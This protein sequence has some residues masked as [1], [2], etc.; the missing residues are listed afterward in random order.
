MSSYPTGDQ[1]TLRVEEHELVVVEVGG[2][3]RTYTV[4]GVDVLAGYEAEEPC[5]A[6]RGQLLIPWPNRIRDGRYTFAGTEHVLPISER[7]TGNASHGLVRWQPWTLA[8]RGDAHLVVESKLHP[9]PGWDWSLDLLMRYEVSELGLTV[10]STARNVDE[11][12][13]PFGYGAHPYISVG[14]LPASVVHLQIPAHRWLR[15]DP[16]RLLPVGLED[17]AGTD[18]DFCESR[19]LGSTSLDTAYTNVDRDPD[20]RWV[21]ALDGL[22]GGT[23]RVWGD[24]AF[25]WVQVFT[26][27]STSD[28]EGTNG[29]AVEPMTC[30]PDAFNSGDDVVVLQ[31]G[32]EWCG[33]WG[34][35]LLPA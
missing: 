5:T 10:T 28:T 32:E 31:P 9:Q 18:R 25:P 13:A 19:E 3:L 34:I 6:G 12:P 26:G 4:G 27:R 20:G 2:G 21:V 30:P 23:V 24:Q 15:V 11:S 16:Q 29:I 8:E 33:Q 7:A 14:D 17:V 22:L 1:W 35:R